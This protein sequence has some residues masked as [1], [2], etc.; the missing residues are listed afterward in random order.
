MRYAVAVLR[1]GSVFPSMHGA[2]AASNHRYMSYYLVEIHMKE[3][4][5]RELER[6]TQVLDAAQSRLR[7]TATVT[8]LIVAGRSDEDGRLLCLIEAGSPELARRLV[9]LALLPAGRVREITPL[10]GRLLVG[11]RDPGGD[12]DPGIEA[13]LVEDVVDMGLD[14]ALGEE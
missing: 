13:E 3:A 11:G 2:R 14:G 8:R 10:A 12:V 1:T 9:S 7:T 6:V 5:R 4:G